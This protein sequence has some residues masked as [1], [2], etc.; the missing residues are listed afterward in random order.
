MLSFVFNFTVNL[1]LTFTIFGNI[2]P[3]IN[4]QLYL[5]KAGD[6]YSCDSDG[7]GCSVLGYG[8]SK[9]RAWTGD[10]VKMFLDTDSSPP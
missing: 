3:R 8:A 9:H 2:L 10:P 7:G 1:N 4:C 6:C 5:N